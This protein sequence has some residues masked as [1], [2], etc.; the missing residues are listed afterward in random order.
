MPNRRQMLS[1]IGPPALL[2]AGAHAGWAT[3]YLTVE[4]IKTQYFP[5]ESLERRDAALTTEQAKAIEKRAQAR[6]K[7]WQPEVWRSKAGGVLVIDRVLGKHENITYG[8]VLDSA[9]AVRA[10]E[11]LEYR[12][13]Y[14]GEIRGARWREQFVGKSASA[15]VKLGKDIKNISGATLSCRHVTDGVRRILAYHEIALR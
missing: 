5:G 10:I 4:Q 9:G 13:T 12:E 3:V 14:G 15:P 2:V 11:V 7:G 1:W 6:A 8:V